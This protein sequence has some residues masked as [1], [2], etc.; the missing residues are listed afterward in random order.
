LYKLNYY[1]FSQVL[2]RRDKAYPIKTMDGHRLFVVNELDVALIDD[3]DD[4]GW[5]WLKVGDIPG[6]PAAA[7]A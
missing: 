6:L 3:H 5:A 2:V 1:N 7:D 4:D